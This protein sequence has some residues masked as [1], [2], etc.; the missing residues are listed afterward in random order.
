MGAD[1][2]L[3]QLI[4]V[5]KDFIR[6]KVDLV[7][8]YCHRFLL[9]IRFRTQVDDTLHQLI[10]VNKDFIREKVDLVIIYCHR[11]LLSIRFRTQVERY[12]P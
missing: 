10:E 8:I 5:N 11:F 4:E 7:I 2:T 1:D 3:H 9:S 12:G 6:E